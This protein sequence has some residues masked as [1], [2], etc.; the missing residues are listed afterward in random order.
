MTAPAVNLLY[1]SSDHAVVGLV[2][3]LK[4]VPQFAASSAAA[5]RFFRRKTRRAR[6]DRL[7]RLPL[8]L[9]KRR[10]QHGIPVVYF[11]PPQL[12]AWAGWAVKKMRERVIG[13]SARCPSRRRVPRA[14]R[15]RPIIGHPYFDEVA[16]PAPRSRF[17]RRRSSPG[18]APSSPCCRDRAIPELTNNLD[19]LLRAAAIVHDNGRTRASW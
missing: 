9:A 5:D 17:S 7:S 3:V 1:P 16:W 10:R 19:S 11:V 14:R 15:R 12:W 18:P 13:R 4:S 2:R 8:V 6:Y